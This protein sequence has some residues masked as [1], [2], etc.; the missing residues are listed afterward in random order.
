[1]NALIE[2]HA[3]RHGAKPQSEE[4]GKQAGLMVG[5]TVNALK[6]WKD[7]ITANDDD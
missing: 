6:H 2:R 1:M 7:S 3:V 4:L 5:D